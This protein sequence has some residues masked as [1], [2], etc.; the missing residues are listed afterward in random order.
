M[1]LTGRASVASFLAILLNV[2]QYGTAMV[3][4]ITSALT[5]LS[6]FTDIYGAEIDLPV[7]FHVEGSA[8]QV[9]AASLGVDAQIHD[10]RGSL[11]FRPPKGA[12][13][14]PAVLLGVTVM[15]GIILWGLGQLQ[16]VFRTLRDGQP[17][18]AANAAR[19][20]SIALIVIFGELARTA[21]MFAS[22]VYA[23]AHFSASGLQFDAQPDLNIFAMIHGLI[24][25]VIAEVFRTGTRLDEDQSL[26]I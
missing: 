6:L 3:I 26:T 25:L 14:V 10:A 2:A 11:K 17:F 1:R 21:L 20:R 23:I 8:L 15:L 5:V 13:V 22:N 16:A 24:I 12:L 9:N 7:A 4:V 18:V 19:I